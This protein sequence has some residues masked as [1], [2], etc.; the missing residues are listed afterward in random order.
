MPLDARRTR[1]HANRVGQTTATCVGGK[2]ANARMSATRA[3]L[4]RPD[5]VQDYAGRGFSHFPKFRRFEGV[6]TRIFFLF[7]GARARRLRTFSAHDP[8]TGRRNLSDSEDFFSRDRAYADPLFGTGC[9]SVIAFGRRE[10]I[11]ENFSARRRRARRPSSPSNRS[12]RTRRGWSATR[13]GRDPVRQRTCGRDTR[14]RTDHKHMFVPDACNP[15]GSVVG[16]E[17]GRGRDHRILMELPTSLHVKNCYT[18][19]ALG[20]VY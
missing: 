4:G 3:S 12:V 5:P 8:C 18:A 7:F 9:E 13:R 16:G 14:E 10:K 17:G 6:G 20:V 1:R 19:V 2:G 11:R 15:P